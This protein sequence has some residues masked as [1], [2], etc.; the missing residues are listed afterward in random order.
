MTEEISPIVEK[1]V[2]EDRTIH[3][4]IGEFV[5]QYKLPVN[6]VN[7]WSEYQVLKNTLP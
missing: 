5:S 6:F 3:T 2:K 4:N 1:E 7:P